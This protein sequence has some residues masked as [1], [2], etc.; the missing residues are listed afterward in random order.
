[1]LTVGKLAVVGSCGGRRGVVALNFGSQTAD[2]PR[3]LYVNQALGVG[4]NGTVGLFMAT[5]KE[6]VIASEQLSLFPENL[7][8]ILPLLP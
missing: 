6:G 5:K 7:H 1:M 2:C 3:L 8:I 4:C